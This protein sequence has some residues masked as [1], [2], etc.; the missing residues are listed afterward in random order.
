[1]NTRIAPSAIIAAL[2]APGLAACT[3]EPVV[4]EYGCCM[5]VAPITPVLFLLCCLLTL[6]LLAQTFIR[7]L[8]RCYAPA[9]ARLLALVG[10]RR[11]GLSSSKLP[12]SAVARFLFLSGLTFIPLCMALQM[13][14]FTPVFGGP[15]NAGFSLWVAGLV[16]AI[17]LWNAICVGL[18]AMLTRQRARQRGT[19]HRAKH[20][21]ANTE[22]ATYGRQELA[23]LLEWFCGTADTAP[24]KGSFNAWSWDD[25]LHA[26]PTGPE[27]GLV[28]ELVLLIE[29]HHPAEKEGDGWCGEAGGQ[30][31]VR[32]AAA[33]RAGTLPCPPTAEERAAMQQGGIPARYERILFPENA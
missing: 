21:P 13:D 23:Q 2:A 4:N 12:E 14:A 1:M 19:P 6:F 32:L 33:L 3:P 17:L 10:V 7:P 18:W 11:E 31:L 20:W 9:L 5:F 26:E 27:D 29:H 22:P 25:F 24:D 8:R 28:R 16:A 15:A 30:A